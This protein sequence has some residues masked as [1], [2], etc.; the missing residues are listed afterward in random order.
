MPEEVLFVS[1]HRQTR[2]DVAAYLRT[3][4]DKLD[5]DAALTLAD[6]DQSVELEPP[7]EVEFEVKVER[8]TGSGPDE[9]GLELELEWDDV[10][11][12]EVSGDEGTTGLDIS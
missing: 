12:D 4:A 6:G 3:V 10:D 9:I 8:E 5:G 7:A 11:T 2:G 1:E